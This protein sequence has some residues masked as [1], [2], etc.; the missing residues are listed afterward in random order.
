MSSFLSLWSS[1]LRRTQDATIT[2]IFS[3][4][5]PASCQH[6]VHFPEGLHFLLKSKA[7]LSYLCSK[8]QGQ[9][10][11][12]K[13]PNKCQ[14]FYTLAISRPWKSRR[15]LNED[16]IS[17]WWPR[18]SRSLLL[19]V[20]QMTMK[21][22]QKLLLKLQYTSVLLPSRYR[23]VELQK[24]VDLVVHSLRILVP[25]FNEKQRSV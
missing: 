14:Y 19:Q 23:E 11:M 12:Q 16:I 4:F 21:T 15:Q 8:Q 7:V 24:A 10:F 5:F 25:I 18:N 2:C 22:V 17:P 9:K 13:C 1:R 20:Y 6:S 3:F